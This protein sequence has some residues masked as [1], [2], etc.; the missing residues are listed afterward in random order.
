MLATILKEFF[1]REMLF[2]SILLDVSVHNPNRDTTRF[3]VSDAGK[4]HRMRYWK[5]QGIAMERDLSVSVQLLLQTGNLLHAWFEY[6]LKEM[7]VLVCSELELADTYRIGHLDCVVKDSGKIVLYDFK[8]TSGKRF[9]FLNQHSG[10]P[11]DE[12][13][14][15]V[16]TYAELYQA[17]LLPLD[18]VRIAYISRDTLE[19]REFSVPL[20]TQSEVKDDWT[21]LI[22]AWEAQEEPPQVDTW[23]CKYCGYRK[24]C[25]P[26][27]GRKYEEGESQKMVAEISPG[28]FIEFQIVV[29]G[30]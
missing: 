1:R 4:C 5:R 7:G 22:K 23:E 6:A 11:L 30:H 2:P 18:E 14:C 28:V 21:R 24:R 3:R 8:T 20:S 17:L 19:I 27:K 10:Q 12:H 29:D 16:M 25:F 9:N 26:V 13:I 15:Q